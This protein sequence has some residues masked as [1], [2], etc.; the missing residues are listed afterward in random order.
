MMKLGTIK[1]VPR[2]LLCVAAL[3]LAS[4]QVATPASRIENNPVLFAALPE[5]DKALVQR[6][7]IRAGM[8][9]EAVFLAWGYPNSQPFV[10]EKDGK[11]MVRWVYTRMEPVMVTP[12]WGGPCWG[13]YGWCHSHYGA[14][15]TA[16]VP[17]NTAYVT[18]EDDKVVSWEARQ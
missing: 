12:T 18:F 7:E 14:P 6:G 11:C 13:P 15:D 5:K 17:R 16:Y 9:P 2:L 8:S 4:C 1:V 3:L 10:G